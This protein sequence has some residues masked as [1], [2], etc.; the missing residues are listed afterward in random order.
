MG[1]VS[2]SS[3]PWVICRA[4][5][6]SQVGWVRFRVTI[7]FSEKCY[8]ASDH[9]WVTRIWLT[10]IP[11]GISHSWGLSDRIGEPMC[12]RVFSRGVTMWWMSRPTSARGCSWDLCRSGE[13]FFEGRVV[14]G[15]I[16]YSKENL[17]INK[18]TMSYTESNNTVTLRNEKKRSE[19]R[20]HCA[21]AVVRRSKK[22]SPHRRPPSRDGQ[23]L[24]S[25]RWSLSSPTNQVWWGSMH[26]ISSYRGNRHTHTQT[27]TTTH[28]LTHTQTGPIT[29]HCAASSAQCN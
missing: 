24:I 20:K 10:D 13:F 2:A 1:V 12:L 28:P 26:A 29:I 5:A 17:K 19:R 11:A 7:F 16:G 22:Y 23:N 18:A 14:E 9:P 3:R 4:G 21:L 25:W 8:C 15:R 6:V 27:H